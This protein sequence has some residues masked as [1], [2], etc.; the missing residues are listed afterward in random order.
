MF[1]FIK[2]ISDASYYCA[3]KTL[4]VRIE[5]GHPFELL[6][7]PCDRHQIDIRSMAN[8]LIKFNENGQTNIFCVNVFI[9]TF[10]II[11]CFGVHFLRVDQFFVDS[12]RSR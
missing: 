7:R 1:K 3:L 11:F 5:T 9:R 12:F 6:K 4:T 8:M 10:S 2:I